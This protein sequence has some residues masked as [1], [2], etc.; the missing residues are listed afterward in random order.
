MK[1]AITLILLIAISIVGSAVFIIDETE[2]AFITQFGKPVGKPITEAGLHFKTP[3]INAVRRFDKRF[4]DW[5]GDAREVTTKDKTFIEIDTYA[6]W[7]I[8]DPLL[9]FQTVI[10]FTGA[11]SRLDDVLDTVTRG[12]IASNELV[13]IVRSIQREPE[14][15]TMEPD[16]R[17]PLPEFQIGRD[18]LA[19]TALGVARPQLADFGIELLDLR[20]KRINYNPKVQNEIFNRM[21]ANRQK[22]A[23]KF[24][25]EGEG[26]AAKIQGQREREL[27]T[28]QSEAYRQTQAI[29]GEGQAKAQSIYSASFNKNQE[30][31]DFFIYLRTLDA[32]L[33]AFQEED[34]LVLTTDADFYRFL[35][36][37]LP[38]QTTEKGKERTP[39]LIQAP[40]SP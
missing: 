18:Q 37:A 1:P 33:T 27:K 5:D 7:R 12:V 17:T 36:R 31:R 40:E 19:Q 23:D 35:R 20:F 28:I 30:A 14:F 8:S 10:N 24:R 39:D 16:E 15:S 32:Y 29:R 26:E 25:S 13:E 38:S 3:F 4:L 2:Q 21:I 34:T 9:F 11:Q 6:R 22:I